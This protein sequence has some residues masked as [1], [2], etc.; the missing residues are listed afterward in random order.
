MLW[1]YDRREGELAVLIDEAGNSRV[2]PAE[3]LP[4]DAREGM[5]LRQE[6]ETFLPDGAATDDRRRHVLSL[7]QRLLRRS[8]KDTE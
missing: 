6:G 5:L 4:A 3:T 2:V 1:S 8:R 7:Q